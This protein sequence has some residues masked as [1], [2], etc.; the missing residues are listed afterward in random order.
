MRVQTVNLQNLGVYVTLLF[1]D[2]R[3]LL[4]KNNS[5]VTYLLSHMLVLGLHC[6]IELSN[7]L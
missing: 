6:V 2:M 1:I 4:I 7:S 5:H 3:L